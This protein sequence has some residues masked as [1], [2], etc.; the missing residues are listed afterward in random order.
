[1]SFMQ[2]FSRPCC[3]YEA[4]RTELVQKRRS[5]TDQLETAGKVTA[6]LTAIVALYKQYD[7]KVLPTKV[8]TAKNILPELVNLRANESLLYLIKNVIKGLPAFLEPQKSSPKELLKAVASD[9]IVG[10]AA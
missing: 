7:P 9:S 8:D 6:N 1:M 3:Q 5:I 10:N 2:G 4:D